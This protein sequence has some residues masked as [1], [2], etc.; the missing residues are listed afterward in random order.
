MTAE[1]FS[2][3]RSGK[4]FNRAGTYNI[5]PNDV[6]FLKVFGEETVS[7]NYT[8]S[9]TGVLSV[10]LIAPM[11]VMGLAAHQ[12]EEKLKSALTR[13]IKNPEVTVIVTDI[14]SMPVFFGGEVARVGSMNLSNKTTILQGILLAGGLTRFASERIIIIRR[15]EDL[16]TRRYETTWDKIL[17]GSDNLDFT[18]L[19]SGDIIIAE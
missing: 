9:P 16:K 7:G 15:V 19:E 6:L 2:S 8:V 5:G 11:S 4:N 18:T 3:V 10:P 17:D 1:P 12:L 13:V 14:R